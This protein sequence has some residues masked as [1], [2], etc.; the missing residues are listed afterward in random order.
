MGAS[1]DAGARRILRGPGLARPPQDEGERVAPP[2]PFVILSPILSSSSGLTRGSKTKP[3]PLKSFFSPHPNPPNPLMSLVCAWILGSS[4]RMT[5]EKFFPLHPPPPNPCLK[6]PRSALGYTGRR[7][8]EVGPARWARGRR[9]TSCTGFAENGLPPATRGEAR[10]FG[11]DPRLLKPE[12]ARRACLCG[13]QG[14]LGIGVAGRCVR[15]HDE[16]SAKAP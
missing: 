1:R 9:R 8:G 5:K 10:G 3:S 6:S 14:G 7:A 4:P 11:P 12:R 15:R 16:R 2:H 13:T